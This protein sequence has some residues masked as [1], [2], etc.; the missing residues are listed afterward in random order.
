MHI[1]GRNLYSIVCIW[2]LLLLF[3]PPSIGQPL[4]ERGI[5]DLSSVDFQV[6]KSVQLNG[7]WGFYWKKLVPPEQLDFDSS[8][9]FV[10]FPHLWNED[11]E[12]SS[13]GYATY[14]VTII[15]PEDHPSLALTIPDLYTAYTLYI[16]D[17]EVSRNGKVATNREAYTPFWLPRTVSIDHFNTDTLQVVL[18]V[19]NFRHSKGGIR[20]PIIL[21]AEE[22]LERERTIEI[23]F[24]LLLT[25]CLFMIGL[26]F[27]GLYLFGRH[28]V[29]MLYF[30]FVCF[31]F[32]YRIFG[33]ELYPLH[34]LFP[35]LPWIL[36]IKAEYF[37]LYF[38]A[39]IFCI[40]VQKL[41]PQ[42]TSKGIIYTFAAIFGVLSLITLFFPP[43]YFTSLINLFFGTIPVALAY[44]TWVYIKAALNK[45]EGAGFALA[46]VVMVFTV[47]MHNL[48]EY[49][50]LLEEN[51]LLN[52]IGFFSFFFLQSLIL[53]YRFTNSLSRARVKAEEAAKAKSQFLST[54]SHEIRTPL[55]AVIGLSDLLLESNSEE[56]KQEFAQ[57]IK[58]SG[59]NLLDIINNILDYSKFESAGIEPNLHPVNVRKAIHE[60]LTML[61]PLS[62]GKNLSVSLDISQDTPEW[63]KTDETHLKQILINLVGNAIKFTSEGEISILVHPAKNLDKPGNLLF[64]ITDTGTGISKKDAHRLFKSF[65][66]VDSSRTRKHG[67]TGLGLVIS[68]KLVEALGGDIW[69]ESEAERGT[70][71]F[72][73]IDAEET[74]PVD[75]TKEDVK[76]PEH[77]TDT[78][79]EAL[80]VLV[81]E[82]NFMNQKVITSILHKNNLNAD[83]ATNG[84]E[85][86]EQLQSKNYDLVFM[87]MEMPVMDGI[88]A[89][90]KIR[91][92]LPE[93]KQPVIIAMTANAFFEDRER[94]L[95]AGM[96]DFL[97]KPISVEMVKTSLKKWFS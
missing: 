6:Q 58:Q 30:A 36:T 73:T 46:S 28:E 18:H 87:D 29:P 78:D 43:F 68:K 10:N 1:S 48:L 42:E 15:K 69:F 57:N 62:S 54:M 60:I 47:F 11:P 72:F 3:S 24:I 40:F 88:E 90:K 19:S 80:K 25:G 7:E 86:L 31:F 61:S 95:K 50:T 65:T 27:M 12:L 41:Y 4:A 8:T 76:Y 13:Y 89:T 49:L 56:E 92:T 81:V 64:E 94:C 71:F 9:S 74:E 22:F 32:S 37:S 55:N 16:N 38:T 79:L 33:T 85:A 66:Q 35:Y 20:L 97:S 96:N 21:G 82:D 67:G 39:S 23:G 5:I 77:D 53:S 91:D 14:N 75:Q 34:Y 17:R 51:L 63:C 52:F 26:F 84:Q 83:I 70:T 93:H 45:R 2:V 59:E 44:I